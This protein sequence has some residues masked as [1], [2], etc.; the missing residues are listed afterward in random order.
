MKNIICS[1]MPEP[2]ED[3]VTEKEVMPD[4]A[5]RERKRE[6]GSVRTGLMAA[7]LMA[8]SMLFAQTTP[9]TPATP[10][11]PSTTTQQ[12]NTA[13]P[14]KGW[15]RFNEDDGRR[16]ELKEDQLQRL[17]EVDN[18]YQDRYD[19]LGKSP[20]TNAGYAPLN[21]ERN[22]AIRG[23][24]SPEQYHKWFTTTGTAP[25]KPAGMTGTTT[26]PAPRP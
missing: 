2:K 19:G 25:S 16:L 18:R 17:Q 13:Q 23:I 7:A 15:T 21:D 9:T 24:L 4:P 26:P 20:A 1:G 6:F 14:N 5:T 10:T 22:D 8:T 12:P 11:T 3:P